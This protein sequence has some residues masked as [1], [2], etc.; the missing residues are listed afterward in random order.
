MDFDLSNI[1]WPDELSPFDHMMFRADSQAS[2]RTS[3]TSVEIFDKAPEWERLRDEMERGTRVALRMRQ[4]VVEPL[5][6]V[7]QPRWVIDPSF[8]LDYHMRHIAL[9]APAGMR[10]LLDLAET[11]HTSPLDMERPLWEMTL[12]EGLDL[13]EGTAAIIW[14][15]SH[16][17]TDGI[18]GMILELIFRH[19]EPDPVLGDMPPEPE[20]EH[21]TPAGLTRTALGR[22]PGAL[23]RS[24]WRMVERSVRAIRRPRET[25]DRA[26]E[27]A[28]SMARAMGGAGVDGS[29]V[30]EARSMHRRFEEHQV[31][32]DDLKAAAK[33]HG[34]SLNDAYLA[35]VCGALRCYHEAK[36]ATTTEIPLAMPM[37]VRS[38]SSGGDM[39]NQ[40]STALF[41]APIGDADP[42]ERMKRIQALVAEARESVGVDPV[43]LIAPLMSK[44][45][46]AL[47]S[48][49]P[50]DAVK[51]DVQA[52]NVPGSPVPRYLA[53]SEVRRMIP[54]GPLPGAAMMVT[55]L[56]VQGICNIGV[57]YDTAAVDDAELFVDCL[58]RGFD[59]VLALG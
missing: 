46:D 34:C 13:E 42:A 16:A 7:T 20:P 8:D 5:T 35:A 14:K 11:I 32:L 3:M 39:S 10:E 53:G 23:T 22:L 41:A 43:H 17:V 9:P 31:S 21:L 37:N 15:L 2:T 33:A 44:I 29:P 38:G 1:E 26:S 50:E 51:I 36:G 40:W 12:V 59:E 27:T 57:N 6:P 47:L 48:L 19:N 54:F 49:V 56:S 28:Q 25:M 55:L 45:P 24:T 18:G 30:L 4:K 52:S 58:R